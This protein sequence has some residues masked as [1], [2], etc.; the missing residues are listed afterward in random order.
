ML[1]VTARTID[2]NFVSPC[3]HE[4]ADT[5]MFLH[6]KHAAFC[7]INSIITVRSDTVVVVIGV[8]VFDDLNVDESWMTFG[9]DKLDIHWVSHYIISGSLQFPFLLGLGKKI[10]VFGFHTGH[11]YF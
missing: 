8:V 7:G 6:A 2:S 1:L 11:P 4:E 3:N 10:V 5:C 9:K